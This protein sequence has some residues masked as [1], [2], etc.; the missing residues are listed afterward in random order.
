MG[1]AHPPD[2]SSPCCSAV[3]PSVAGENYPPTLNE[4]LPTNP[5]NTLKP[6]LSKAPL[7]RSTPVTREAVH[8]E[9]ICHLHCTFLG[10]SRYFRNHCPRWDG[11]PSL[12]GVSRTTRVCFMFAAGLCFVLD[13]T[14][15][16]S[17]TILRLGDLSSHFL[18]VQGKDKSNRSSQVYGLLYKWKNIN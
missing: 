14:K 5:W 13:Y 3:L 4:S 11:G 18:V 10:P 15:P 1:S 6:L 12:W 8:V 17:K 9:T 7:L 2:A 16:L